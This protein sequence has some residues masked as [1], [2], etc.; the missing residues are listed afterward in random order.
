M[1]GV[2]VASTARTRAASIDIEDHIDVSV[3]ID[4][5][6]SILHRLSLSVLV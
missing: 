4:I 1:S 5:L 6:K 3:S 2:I